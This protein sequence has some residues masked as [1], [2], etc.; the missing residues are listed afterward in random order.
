MKKISVMLFLIRKNYSLIYKLHKRFAIFLFKSN[1]YLSDN[2]IKQWKDGGEQFEA[3]NCGR[4]ANPVLS[5]VFL[6]WRQSISNTPWLINTT[7]REWN[8]KKLS[9]YQSLLLK[10]LFSFS[11]R[12]ISRRLC[13]GARLLC[14][15][16]KWELSRSRGCI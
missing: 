6:G 12:S 16:R 4:E 10:S 14:L 3:L 2:S 13:R 15:Y 1:F 5:F 8:Q 7:Q 9:F 11:S